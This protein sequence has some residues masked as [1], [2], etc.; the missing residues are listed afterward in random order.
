MWARQLEELLP[1]AT[2][3]AEKAI[4]RLDVTSHEIVRVSHTG[5]DPTDPAEIGTPHAPQSHCCTH[6]QRLSNLQVQD[7]NDRY[8]VFEILVKPPA[9]PPSG[10]L[11][12]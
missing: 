8:V 11:C 7:K 9:T 5:P 3:S 12:V 2:P 10:A 1:S 4:E 6:A